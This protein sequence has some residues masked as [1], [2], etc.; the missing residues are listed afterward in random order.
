MEQLALS[1]SGVPIPAPTGIPSGGTSVLGTILG[2][3]LGLLFV[4]AVVLA[5]IYLIAGGIRWTLSGGDAKAIEGARKQITYA[6]IGLIVVFI[7][8][9]IVSIIGGLFKIQLF[10]VPP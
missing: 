1:I 3:F 9:F 10:E 4:I 8:F 7:A 2:G 5:V 6:I